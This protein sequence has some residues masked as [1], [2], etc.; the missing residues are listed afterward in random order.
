METHRRGK[1]PTTARLGTVALCATAVLAVMAPTA[2]ARRHHARAQLSWTVSRGVSEGTPIPFSWS[3]RHLGKK[4]RL[5]VQRPVGTARTWKTML[6]LKTRR[7]SG[8]LPEQALGKYRFRLAALRGHRVLASK[9]VGIGVFG[10]VPFSVLFSD[11]LPGTTFGDLESGVY[12]TSSISFPYIGGVWAGARGTPNTAFSIRNNPCVA[13][14]IAF[15]LGETPGEGYSRAADVF[16]VVSLVQQSRD[17]VTSEVPL[18]GLGSMDAELV[19]GQSWS[20][21]AVE[22]SREGVSAGPTVYFNGYAVCDS[23]ESFFSG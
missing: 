15:V 7:G 6:K 23:T 9:V 3:S 22:N 17:P 19:P 10:P 13:V 5:V 16:G 4:Y 11:S 8:V 12:A 2:S 18:N 20:L 1:K 21:L 14:H